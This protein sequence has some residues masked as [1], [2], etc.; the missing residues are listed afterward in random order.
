MTFGVTYANTTHFGENVRGGPG[1]G[2]IVMF[3]Q[4]LP[5]RRSAFAVT[6]EVSGDVLIKKDYYPW[7]NE[8]FLVRHE[9]VAWLLSGGEIYSYYRAQN[10]RKVVFEPILHTDYTLYSVGPK[11]REDGNY[12]QYTYPD[13]SVSADDLDPSFKRL[14]AI[15]LGKSQ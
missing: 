13:G 5:Q 2:L 12:T 3:D 7:V 4:R 14:Q 15:R 9:K 6:H 11:V 1:G 8:Q 10:A